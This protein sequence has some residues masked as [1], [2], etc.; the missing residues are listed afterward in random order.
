MNLGLIVFANNSGLGNQTRRL[1]YML[2]PNRVLAIDSTP[3]SKNKKQHFDWYS[4]FAGYKVNG[5]PTNHEINVFLNG[6]THVFL[7][8]TPLNNELLA[9]CKNRGIKVFIQSNYEFC[10]HLNNKGLVLPYKFLMPSFWHVD[11]MQELFGKDKVIYLPPPLDPNEFTNIRDINLARKNN[12]PRFLHI[13]GTLAAEDR[14]G[15]L[16]LLE[17]LQHTNADFELVIHSQ[18]ELP[19]EYIIN[20]KRVTYRQRDFEDVAEMYRDFDA[21]VLPRRYG[22]LSLTTNEGLS[23]GLPV[24]MSDI[25]PNNRLLKK[26]WLFNSTLKKQFFTRTLIDVYKSSAIDIAKRIDWYCNLKE[27]E[28]L[29]QKLDA[30]QLAYDNFSPAVLKQ[31]Y[32]NLW[33]Q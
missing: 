22:G 30:V 9:M 26:S 5:V 8:E 18:H 29:T 10:D 19:S 20:D 23:S 21:L 28:R 15:T 11:T 24:I 1:A 13:V 32:D 33:K 7:C 2:Q 14:N 27:E 6:L 25:S 3:F 12:A 31:E 16:D 4:M 17:A